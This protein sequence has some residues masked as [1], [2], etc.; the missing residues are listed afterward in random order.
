M[1]ISKIA[2]GAIFAGFGLILSGSLVSCQSSN[3]SESVAP[4]GAFVVIQEVELGK[5]KILEE[6][7]SNETRIVLKKL[8][9][10]EQVLTK[11]ELD[12]LLK[13][14]NAKIDNGTSNLTN[15][16][17]QLSSGGLS[18]GEAILASAAGAI[19]GSYIGNKLFNNPAFQNKRAGAYS[20]PS[21]YSRSVS[22]FSSTKTPTQ[23]KSGFFK[24]SSKTSSSIGG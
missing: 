8:D 11:E 7:P 15:P 16:S 17:A 12:E 23:A 9:G 13:I 1:K 20:N 19:I 6:F 3:D 24:N 22:Q 21:A 10:S 18:L 5:Y 14:E 2:K 4:K